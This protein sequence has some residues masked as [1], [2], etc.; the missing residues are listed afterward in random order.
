MKV[1]ISIPGAV[2]SIEM[3]DNRAE[4]TF[5]ELA[6]KLIGVGAEIQP[7]AKILCK[8]FKD[9]P[10]EEKQRVQVLFDSTIDNYLTAKG[11]TP[12]TVAPAQPAEPADQVPHYPLIQKYKGFLYI[13]CEECGEVRGFCA[14][15]LIRAS[16]CKC[17]H[18][19]ELKDLNPLHVHCECGRQFK[20]MTNMDEFLFDINCIDCGSP[21]PVKW[22][23][24]K[25]LYETIK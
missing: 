25:R 12:D 4:K 3:E 6:G 22:N 23:K 1:R 13:K 5:R 24:N 11:I 7:R 18:E 19:T 16:R 17:G 21:V 9:A 10:E 20:Y 2:V 14:K 8:G 15:E